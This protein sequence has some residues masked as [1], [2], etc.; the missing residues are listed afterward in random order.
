MQ[1]SYWIDTHTHLDYDYPG[2]AEGYLTRARD[3][4]VKG[5]ISIGANRDHWEKIR[6][7]AERHED[8]VFTV[9]IHPNDAQVFNP[10][11]AQEMRTFL[12]HPKCVALGEIG[13]DYHYKEPLPQIQKDAFQD[14]FELAQ[15]FGKPIVIH[16]RLGEEDLLDLLRK[17]LGPSATAKSD[18]QKKSPGVIHCF[19]GTKPF[20]QA[21]LELGFY[22]SFSGIL[23]FKNA[24]E[25]RDVAKLTPLDRILV[26]TDAPYLA[27]VPY[28][29]KP[30]ESM[31]L[32]HT[33]NLLAEIKGLS[34]EE[35]ASAT[36]QNARQCFGNW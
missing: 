20:A 2:D 32:P 28:R 24:Q 25:I 18:A 4:G 36:T 17:N 9:G 21:C 23:T 11:V 13:L 10:S 22:I 5:F 34:R 29:G 15:E 16:S 35:M 12:A 33:G 26:E 30:N 3:A 6:D 1:P 7:L 19:S 14:Q 27:P 31:F 8:V